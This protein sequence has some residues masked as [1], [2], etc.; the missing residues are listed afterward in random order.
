VSGARIHL[1]PAVSLPLFKTYGRVVPRIAIRHTEY[2]LDQSGTFDDHENRTVPVFS[3][4]SYL[5]A[6]RQ[7]S[8]FG[9]E[10]LQTL[11]PRAYYL[12]IPKQDQDDIPIFD[13]GLFDISFQN[14]FRDD[15]FTGR[16]RVGDTNQMS[17]AVTSRM[18]NRATGREVFRASLG[19]IY[20]FRDRD[21][22][23]PGRRRENGDMSELIAE[24]AARIGGAWSVR[25]T[26]QY[27][28][29]D[30]ETEKAALALRYMPAPGRIVNL[31]Y[32]LRRATTDV[33]QTDVSFRWPLTQQLSLVGRWN[34]SLRTK[35]SLE[36]MGGIEYESC[37][38]GIR[39]VTRRFIRNSEGEFDTAMFVQ[40][41]L[42]GLSGFGRGTSSFLRKSI[43]GY[44]AYF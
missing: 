21:V 11:E 3:V 19:Q 18:L 8:A 15:R 41:E 10:F 5:F 12:L 14:L 39:L 42:K 13:T 9:S 27:D 7:F 17:L 40:F 25:S 43:P 37:C 20:F 30:A 33:E 36:A 6:E 32:R 16:D 26:L 28:P 31:S 34:Y 4:D 38:W 1:E 22:T 2:L 44:E 24:V 35:Q 29:N 23:L